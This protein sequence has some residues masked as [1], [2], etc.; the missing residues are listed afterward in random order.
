MIVTKKVLQQLIDEE[1][2]RALEKRK[3]HLSERIHPTY[4]Q[5]LNECSAEALLE[6]AKAYRSM[7]DAVAEQLL[8]L[9]D[10]PLANI[11]PNA[12]DEM[13]RALGGVNQEIDIAIESWERSYRSDE[14]EDDGTL[15]FGNDR[16]DFARGT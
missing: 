14:P 2:S 10:D 7:G 1:F 9:L 5:E 15:G 11:N 8:K 6:F 16:K 4:H 12:V 13:K 3:K